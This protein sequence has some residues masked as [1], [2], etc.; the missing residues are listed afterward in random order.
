MKFI[1]KDYP[2]YI[3]N[4]IAY[5]GET[6]GV[7]GNDGAYNIKNIYDMSGCSVEWTNETNNNNMVYRGS[8]D[9]SYMDAGIISRTS[10]IANRYYYNQNLAAFRIA[11]YINN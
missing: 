9:T 10:I 8:K 4:S 2:D 1:E 11:L 5:E 7:T 3:T 6:N